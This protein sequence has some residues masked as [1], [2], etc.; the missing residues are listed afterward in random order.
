VRCRPHIVEG[1]EEHCSKLVTLAGSGDFGDQEPYQPRLHADA[2]GTTPR[3]II[4]L[5]D[6]DVAE[7][8]TSVAG[9]LL[10]AVE[11]GVDAPVP[12]VSVARAWALLLAAGKRQTAWWEGVENP[13]CPR[14]V[15]KPA[16]ARRVRDAGVY[17]PLGSR[18]QGVRAGGPE[19][20]P[21]DAGSGATAERR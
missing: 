9:V 16:G 5:G 12:G 2:D 6:D 11:D 20:R 13:P 19:R 17:Q 7:L 21:R 8:P 18:V 14:L 15:H 4:K 10:E 1:A 3:L